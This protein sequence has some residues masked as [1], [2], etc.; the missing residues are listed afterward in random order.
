M[1]EDE[2]VPTR[3]DL[4]EDPDRRAHLSA[5]LVP[6]ASPAGPVEGV[7]SKGDQDPGHRSSDRAFRS[8]MNSSTVEWAPR[9]SEARGRNMAI[10]PAA[11]L[12]A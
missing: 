8:G 4:G 12:G 2:R 9:G 11:G 5:G 10:Y 7:A 3:G 6:G 1:R